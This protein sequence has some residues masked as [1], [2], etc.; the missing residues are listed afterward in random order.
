M[1][2]QNFSSLTRLVK[3]DEDKIALQAANAFGV[4]KQL[5]SI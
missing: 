2:I 4:T 1:P 3:T 5:N